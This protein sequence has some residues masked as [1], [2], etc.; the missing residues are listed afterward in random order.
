MKTFKE[1]LDAPDGKKQMLDYIDDILNIIDFKR[2]ESVMDFLRWGWVIGDKDVD[3]LL[4][5]GYVVFYSDFTEDNLYVPKEKDIILAA[6]RIIE[7]TVERALECEANYDLSTKHF[8]VSR[9]GFLCEIDI[10]DDDRRK[11]I[12]GEDAPDD[13]E[14]SVD[15]TLKFILEEN[16]GKFA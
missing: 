14:H 4:Q 3:D 15:I 11:R 16:L 2:I 8:S 1:Y 5:E 12:W 13:F 6:R 7:D 9:A 10:I